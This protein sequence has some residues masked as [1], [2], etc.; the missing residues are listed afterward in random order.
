MIIY[1]NCSYLF[2][3]IILD[4]IFYFFDDVHFKFTNIFMSVS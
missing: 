2:R 3:K 1:Y 4:V